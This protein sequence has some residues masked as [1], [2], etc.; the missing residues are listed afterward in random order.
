MSETREYGKTFTDEN[1][2]R[3]VQVFEFVNGVCV[4][5]YITKAGAQI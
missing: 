5:R 1:G 4:D 3:W 2:V